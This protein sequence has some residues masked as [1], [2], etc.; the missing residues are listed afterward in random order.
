M[1]F[2]LPLGIGFVC[3]ATVKIIKNVEKSESL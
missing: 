3:F 1:L 2:Y